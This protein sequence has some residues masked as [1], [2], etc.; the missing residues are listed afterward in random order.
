M[1]LLLTHNSFFFLLCI[2]LIAICCF[3]HCLHVFLRIFYRYLSTFVDF[4]LQKK[5]VHAL[6]GQQSVDIEWALGV[7]LLRTVEV[8]F[9]LKPLYG[10]L[11]TLLKL[12]NYQWAQ[13]CPDLNNILLT[14]DG[15]ET[16]C[17]HF[18]EEVYSWEGVRYTEWVNV[19][20]ISN[21]LRNL[22]CVQENEAYLLSHRPFMNTVHRMFYSKHPDLSLNG[23]EIIANLSSSLTLQED[24]TEFLS[25]LFGVLCDGNPSAISRTL[26][27]IAKMSESSYNQKILCRMDIEFFKRLIELLSVEDSKT[28]ET[29]LVIL[30]NFLTNESNQLRSILTQHTRIIKAL[31][32]L[33]ARRNDATL[34]DVSNMTFPTQQTLP[35]SSLPSKRSAIAEK[36][37]EILFYFAI[38]QKNRPSLL[39]YEHFFIEL[40]ITVEDNP[41]VIRVITEL[42]L[43][44]HE[45]TL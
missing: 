8:D 10:L 13:L 17:F 27:V 14:E 9:V 20:Q 25:Y 31:I 24:N 44:L 39:Q 16:I 34:T 11:D 21:I 1:C 7:L 30:C 32:G 19:L 26:E 41:Q 23:L 12:V 42:L 5:L 45:E 37:T 6:R 18:P 2:A 22:S 3:Q 43:L 28:V 40:T 29:S 38:E 36:A 4:F 15:Q 35:R 33:L